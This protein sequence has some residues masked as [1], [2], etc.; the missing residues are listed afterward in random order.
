MALSKRDR[1]RRATLLCCHFTR[2]LTY[3]RAGLVN[4]KVLPERSEFW[5]TVNGNFID[6]AVL[7]C[8]KLL[9]DKKG[10]HYWGKVVSDPARFE[11]EL[12]QKIDR[13]K[14]DA[15]ASEMKTYRD[16][17]V[18]HLDE[19]PV[20][21]IPVLDLAYEAVQFYHEYMKANEAQPG[22]LVNLLD[23]LDDYMGWC[24]QDAKKIYTR[25]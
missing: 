1:L 9:V 17:F 15:M 22:D 16:K 25:S 3:Y 19:L 18:A 11:K 2:N 13:A 24:E 6:Q 10:Q 4:G 20:M 5:V 8:C 12:F 21:Q 14:F 23:D 7:E